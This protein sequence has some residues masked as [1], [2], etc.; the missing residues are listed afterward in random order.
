MNKHPLWYRIRGLEKME[1]RFGNN[2]IQKFIRQR[3]STENTVRILE[4]GFGEGVCLLELRALFPDKRVKFYGIND[5][6]KGNMK[7]RSDFLENAKKFGIDVPKNLLPKPFFYD[8]GKG[9]HFDD[10]YFDAIISQVAIPYVG[11][12]SKLLEEFWRVLKPQ[13]KA[14]LHI[15]TYEKFYPDFLQV[16]KETPR[17]VIYKKGKLI[18]VSEHL[19]KFRKKGFDVRFKIKKGKANRCV[20][21]KKTTTK[22]LKLGLRYDEDSSFDLTRFNKEKKIR[23]VWWGTRS[24]FFMK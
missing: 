1:A 22:P 9:L 11:D 14:F 19:N 7:K 3:L 20:L 17:F 23:G 12:K 16:S 24:V 6:K 8:A 4:L 13:G 5:I 18:K 2:L 21:M 15:D 10:N